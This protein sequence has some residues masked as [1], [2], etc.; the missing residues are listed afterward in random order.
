MSCR[1]MRNQAREEK[2]QQVHQ[3]S[4]NRE[5]VSELV[6][7][8]TTQITEYFLARKVAEGFTCK[9]RTRSKIGEAGKNFR[10]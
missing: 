10:N 3:E 2:A 8:H 4:G 7:T 6:T 1:V 5:I 9:S